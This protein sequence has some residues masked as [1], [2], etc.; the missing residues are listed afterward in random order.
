MSSCAETI[1]FRRGTS[2]ISASF[3]LLI[4]VFAGDARAADLPVKAPPQPA[5]YD[6]TGFYIGGHVGL[7]TGNSG[8]KLAPVGGAPAGDSFGLYQSPNAFTEA[9]SWFE[10]AQA[11]YNYMLRNR[12]VVGVEA[13]GSFP[14]FPDLVTGLTI[15]GSSNFTSPSFGAGS[16]SETVRASGTVRGRIGYAPDHWLFYGTSGLAWTYDHETLTQNASGNSEDRFLYRFG[17]A[18]G[19]GVETAIAPSWT[20][21]GEYLWTDFPSMTENF[22]L[23]GQRVNSGLSEHQLRLALNYRFDDPSRPAAVAPSRFAENADIFAVHGQATFVEQAHPAFHSPYEGPNS[24]S[25][26]ADAKETFDTTLS[27][28]VK[29]WRGAEFWANPEID[30]G[31][32]FDSTHGVAG[33]VSAEAYKIGSSTPYARLQRA[34]LRQTINLGGDTEKVDDDF[35]QFKGTRSTDRLVLTVGRFGINDIF[36]TN[37]YANNPKSDFL[38]WSL[39]NAGTF[40]YAGDGWGYSYGAAGEWYTGQ[41]TLRAGVFDLSATPAGGVSPLGGTLDP[42][43]QQFQLVGEIERRY[44]LGG[45]PGKIKITGFLSNGRAGNFNDAVALAQITGMPADINAVRA[46]T[47]RPGVSLNVEQQVMDNLGVFL[48]AGWADGQIEP[49]DFTDIDRTVSGGV[50]I[51]GKSWGRPDDTIG[52]AGVVNGISSAHIAFL[53]TGGLGIL[54]GDGQLTNYGLEKILEAYYSIALNASTKLTFDYQFVD[55]PGYN[56]DRGPANVFAGRLHW[57]F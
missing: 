10:G 20:V 33:F 3:A 15:G 1:R 27:I 43:F 24:L 29:L 35:T 18:A 7:A 26:A 28:G 37:K 22:P 17:W 50:S 9:G 47:S 56:A 8:W 38:N 57:Q 34:F 36:D 11:G 52:I 21:R 30:Q 44:D 40:D 13:D 32:G 31:F 41:W 23:S 25:G 5:E 53:N 14:P 55:N 51:G 48:R 49:W 16:F 39:V 19:V 54:I 2:W 4:S 42:T 45:Q 46:Y 12:M 6:W